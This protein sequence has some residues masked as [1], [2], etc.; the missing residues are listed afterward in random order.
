MIS[1]LYNI[2][3]DK[4][5]FSADGHKSQMAQTQLYVWYLENSMNNLNTLDDF[6]KLTAAKSKM[7][8]CSAEGFMQSCLVSGTSSIF[9]QESS[10][11]V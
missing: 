2:E 9:M 3:I 7:P 4:Q 6:I 11:C 8:Y 1:P 10:P 5:K